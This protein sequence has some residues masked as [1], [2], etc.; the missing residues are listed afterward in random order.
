MPEKPANGHHRS[1]AH[2]SFTHTSSQSHSRSGN[3]R[4]TNSRHH[5]STGN[6]ASART[7]AT[8]T[9]SS[10]N[11]YRAAPENA[12]RVNSSQRAR[13]AQG[14]APQ[15][16]RHRA[17]A[18]EAPKKKSRYIPALDGLRALA[19]LGVIAYHM[20]MVWMPGGLLGVTVFFVLSG[21]L[22]TSLLLIEWD[23]TGTINLP[24]FWL[25]RVKRLFPAIAFVILCVGALCTVF[26]HSLLTKLRED[27]WAALCWVTNWWYI[28]RD[29]SYFDALGAPSPVTHF[30]SLAIE[31][32]FYLIWP[33]VLIVAHKLGVKR[34][35]MRNAT[36]VLVLASALEMALL[37]SPDAD[38]SRVYYGTDT[39]AFSLLI[40]AWLAFVWPSNQLGATNEVHLDRNVRVT[41]DA[42]G[43]IAL[44]GL[45]AMMACIEGTSAFMY[46]GGI[47]LASI[48]TMMVIAVIVHPSSILGKA[49][50]AKPL[51]WIGLRSY[52][53][54]LW[55]YP[56]LLLMNPRSNIAGTP[57]W[58]YI[59]EL[60]VICACAAFSY[61]FVEDPIRHG[62]IGA[63]IGR[64]RSGE[65]YLA[66]WLRRHA[67]PTAAAAAVTLVCVGGLIFVPNTSA[68]EGGDLLKDESAH[69]AGIPAN[70]SETAEKAKLDVL[71]IGDSVSVRA[72]P[73]FTAAFP[74]GAIDAAVNRQLTVGEAVYDS[75]AQQNIVGDVVVFAL[76]T[77][78][79]VTDEQLDNLLS[80]V[81]ADKHVFFV[82]TRSPQTWMA[83]TN[84]ALDRAAERYSNVQVIDWY[85]AS[86]PHGDW[87]DGDGTHLSE[88][89]AQAYI[90]L[91]H[92]AIADLL[93]EHNAN[94]E[95]AQVETPVELATNKTVQAQEAAVRSLA[96]SIA[97]N[98]NEKLAEN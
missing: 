31:E 5:V 53:I 91:V 19:V 55:H 94:D 48:I 29:V 79:Q 95:V 46:R 27:M 26:D 75:Y 21:Y 61:K 12:P 85:S 7:H 39:R 62:S 22:I 60:V 36:L 49:F 82:N 44:I 2:A 3:A 63:F 42:V 40:G 83:E 33:V 11:A 41:L 92:D 67:I 90:D 50:S 84:A 52:G 76:G 35:H 59:I 38:P 88:E 45:L 81:G 68:L 69:I 37:F 24:Q 64:V 18:A 13:A 8:G 47:L 25:R 17:V 93:P 14:A 34:S 16:K 6:S 51:V 80:D 98:L 87:F 20:G 97:E 10:Q 86:A 43:G 66:D 89:G 77:N 4:A 57:W 71:M 72:I 78:G 32:Q 54:Y 73:N 15:A 56:L 70:S 30:W 1:S 58:M 65:V 96:G 9:R 28:L 74:Y 23:N